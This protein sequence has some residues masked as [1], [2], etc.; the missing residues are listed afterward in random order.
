MKKTHSQDVARIFA[1]VNCI[2][3]VPLIPAAVFAVPALLLVMLFACAAL[4]SSESAAAGLAFLSAAWVLA[5][6]IFS[7]VRL[8]TGYFR[9]YKGD[10]TA[11][12]IDRLWFKT[13][14]YNAVFFFPSLYFKLRCRLTGI[15]GAEDD[16]GLSQ[17]LNDYSTVFSALVLWWGLAIFLAF[18]ALF[19]IDEAA[20][21][22]VSD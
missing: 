17:L 6:F 14:A 16:L 12:E 10:L 21:N 2:F 18:S 4:F 3:L 11:P 7:G 22:D 15:C 13:I 9:H 1:L 19:S 8:L 20:A 5:A